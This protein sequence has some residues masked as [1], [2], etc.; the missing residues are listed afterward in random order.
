MIHICEI[1]LYFRFY[2]MEWQNVRRLGE[3][4]LESYHWDGKLGSEELWW[5]LQAFIINFC[6]KPHLALDAMASWLGA[7][8]WTNGLPFWIPGRA[9][10]WVAARS[11]P[12]WGTCERQPHVYVSLPFFL[13][14]FP[15]SKNKKKIESKFF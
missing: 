5:K 10:A 1:T 15:L 11:G 4:T 14:P 2:L 3:E 13:S 12:Q 6:L 9:H 8:L 7:S